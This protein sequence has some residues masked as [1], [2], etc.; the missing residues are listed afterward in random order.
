MN[1]SWI[2]LGEEIK[3]SNFFNKK[4]MMND[5][6]GGIEQKHLELK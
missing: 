4:W 5:V 3:V 6:M 1:V 2:N